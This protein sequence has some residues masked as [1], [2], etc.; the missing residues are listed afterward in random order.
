MASGIS[1][2]RPDDQASTSTYSDTKRLCRMAN[3]ADQLLYGYP[4]G[5]KFDSVV[6]EM[7][8]LTAQTDETRYGYDFTDVHE[9]CFQD[10]QEKLK[11]C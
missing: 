11:C 10:L 8:I 6:Y 3:L 5:V 2:L 9:D 1:G 7:M 4:P